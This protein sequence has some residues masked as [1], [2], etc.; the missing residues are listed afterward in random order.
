MKKKKNPI[1]SNMTKYYMVIRAT[2]ISM[3][4]IFS[5]VGFIV[6]EKRNCLGSLDKLIFLFN[7]LKKI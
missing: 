7:N 2:S 6:N 4:R 1:L 3:E 5:N